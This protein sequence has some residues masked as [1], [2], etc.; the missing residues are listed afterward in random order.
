[1]SSR[2]GR[3]LL[4]KA[5]HK[6]EW[7]GMSEASRPLD[8]A[9]DEGEEEVDEKELQRREEER[10]H[11]VELG[12]EAHAKAKAKLDLKEKNLHAAG[13]LSLLYFMQRRS[14]PLFAIASSALHVY[15]CRPQA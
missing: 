6:K 15:V 2:S 9:K 8:E 11:A 13:E 1:M 14:F 12:Q 4:I 10:Q 3:C 7:S 5:H